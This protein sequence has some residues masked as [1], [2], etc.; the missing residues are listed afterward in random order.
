VQKINSW[1]NYPKVKNQ[2]ITSFNDELSFLGQS[3]LTSGLGRSYGDVGL[4]ENGTLISTE[5]LTKIISFDEKNGTLNCE[6]GLSIKEILQFIIPKGWFLPVVPG[7]RNVTIGG[8]IA[9]DIHGKNHHKDGTFGN[10]VK[11]IKLLRSDGKIL[12]CNRQENIDYLNSTIAG[13]GLTGLIVSAEI[14][15]KKIESE[16]IDVKTLKFTS[17]DEYWEINRKFEKDYD[18]TVSWVDCL[19]N[20]K[21]GIRGIYIAGNHSKNITLKNSKREL[22]IPFPLT[23]PFSFVNNIS[24]RLLNYFYYSLNKETEESVQHYKKFFF[25]LDVIRNWNKAYGKKGFFQYQFVVPKENA[26]F[27]LK[28]VLEVLKIKKQV[29]AL[30]VLKNFGNIKSSGLLSFPEEGVTLALDFPNKG[31]KTLSLFEDLNKIIFENGGRLYPAK[32]AL[33]KAEEFQKG[34]KKLDEFKKFVDPKFSSSFWR[35]VSQ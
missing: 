13:L 6:S 24:M 29:P 33:M 20:Q 3:Y 7:T 18:Y 34:Y 22:S 4:N 19:Y 2:K 8:A 30:G 27:V 21:A 26:S 16:F 1:G 35:R 10:H 9:N 32:D 12:D 28:K 25:P 17:L 23:P 31:A 5:N 14:E 15:L 11:S